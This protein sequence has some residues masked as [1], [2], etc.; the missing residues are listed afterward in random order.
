VINDQENGSPLQVAGAERSHVLDGLRGYAAIAVVF[1]HTILGPI[2]DQIS[3][4]LYRSVSSQ[5]T[6]YGIALK[7]AVSILNGEVA[8]YIFFVMSG[9]VLFRSLE[10]MHKRSGS[11]FGTSWRFLVRR[12]LR[13]WPVMAVCLIAKFLIFHQ[14]NFLRP[15]TVAAPTPDDLIINLWLIRFPVHGATWTLFVELA[16]API[17]LL[18]FFAM[19]RLGAWA[20]LAFFTYALLAIFQYHALMFNS[21]ELMGGV[22]YLLAGVAI[23]SGWL[24]PLMRSRLR[25]P[26]LLAALAALL[27]NVLFVSAYANFKLH[28]GGLLLSIPL[29]VGGVYIARD[30]IVTR[31]LEAPLSQFFGRTSFSLYLW[32]VPIFELLFV[33]V[34]PEFAHAHPLEVG[35]VV[36]IV[37][38]LLTLPVAHLSEIWLEQPCIHLGRMLMRPRSAAEPLD[39]SRMQASS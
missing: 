14:I 2:H 29:L 10:S 5:T 38:V 27:G 30:S 34:K 1:Y 24:T 18:C 11:I 3:E 16:A 31:F 6:A 21:H 25:I 37:A 15:N 17:L 7:V 4:L 13:I 20:L 28:Y 39:A 36:G 23:A 26:V 9:I 19:R 22:P 32:N 33:L 8:V 12:F 35:L